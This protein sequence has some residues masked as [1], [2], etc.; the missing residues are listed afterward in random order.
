V[1]SVFRVLTA[2]IDVAI[3][4]ASVTAAV[5][6]IAF[7]VIVVSLHVWRSEPLPNGAIRGVRCHWNGPWLIARGTVANLSD[8][9]AAFT[10]EP[11]LAAGGRRRVAPYET[12]SLSVPAASART[13]RWTDDN[14]RVPPGTPITRCAATVLPPSRGEGD[15]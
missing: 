6:V 14:I 3:G 11:D 13:W 12:D 15:D 9:D 4:V 2:A 5:V 7:T 1:R 10:V 8:Q